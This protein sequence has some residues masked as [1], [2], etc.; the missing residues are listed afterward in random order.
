M[1][2]R[3]LSHIDR[4]AR[5]RP[6]ACLL[7]I[8]FASRVAYVLA[9]VRFDDS[10]LEDTWQLLDVELLTGR[11]LESC[12]YL[13]GQPPLMNLLVGAVLKLSPGAAATVF[14]ALYLLAGAAL[15]ASVLALQLRLGVSH[16]VALLVAAVFTAS[17][18]AVL[19]E[20]WLF[21]TLPVA[22]L[23]A[24]S[25]VCFARAV[26][27][28]RAAPAWGLFGL[29]AA[30]C[31]M[32]SA[33]HLAWYVLAAALLLLACRGARRRMLAP[34]A[35]GLLLVASVYVKNLVVFGRFTTSTWL[36]MNAWTMTAR[37]L[38][39][40]RREQLA[41]DGVISELSLVERFG[42]LERYPPAYR[43]ASGY[44][45]VPAVQRARK[46][47][48]Q[49]NYNHAAYIG[50]SDRYL[51]DAIAVGRRHP[52]T[53][54]VGLGRSWFGYFKSASD[55][56]FLDANR[57]RI[58]PVAG[59]YDYALFGKL[60]YNLAELGWLPIHSDRPHYAY[61]LLLA[62]LPVL[63]AY[64]LAKGLG[65]RGPRAMDRDERMLVL[66]LCLNILYVALAGNLLETGENNR[67]RFVT[68][69]FYAVLAGMLICRVV[70]GLSRRLRGKPSAPR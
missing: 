15:A 53:L 29:L 39:A 37:N 11:L 19:Y 3:V 42:P 13:H 28:G 58:A 26:R 35:A 22:A 7:A 8:F 4:A 16:R 63:V 64:G 6:F 5:R 30:V 23:L 27:T 20:N 9:G 1:I 57:A 18:A 41:A 14:A 34:A 44:P 10:T 31:L 45:D 69:A 54:A 68:D 21:Y 36:G 56:A 50:I 40:E 70:D 61:L 32:R 47:G 59:A 67:F 62:G 24:V 46:S 51:A 49:V 55:Y 65:R 17:P 38:P 2:R 66:Y 43:D 52:K 60:P 25:A 12:Y 48:G 33:F